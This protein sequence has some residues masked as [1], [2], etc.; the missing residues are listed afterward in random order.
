VVVVDCTAGAVV[1]IIIIN[2]IPTVTIIPVCPPMI[3]TTV[4]V[5]QPGVVKKKVGVATSVVGY[6]LY[7]V[8]SVSLSL[9]CFVIIM[10]PD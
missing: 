6:V 9:T 2:P 10:H 7:C 1:A 4:L 5:H 8:Y 3:S